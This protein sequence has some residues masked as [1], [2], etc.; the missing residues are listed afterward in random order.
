MRAG[1]ARDDAVALLVDGGLGGPPPQRLPPSLR[2]RALV[3]GLRDSPA[4]VH[5]LALGYAD[6]PPADLGLEELRLRAERLLVPAH[7]RRTL[8][9]VR[10]D[11]VLR[12][13]LAGGRRLR[14][15]PREFALLWRLSDRPGEA[16]S[17]AELLRDVFDLAFDP[18]TNSLA[19]H[20][21]RLRK[22]LALAGLPGLVV[23][24]TSTGAYRLD[25][26][27]ASP[28]ALAFALAA[29]KPLDPSARLGEQ[30]RT[31]EE[32]AP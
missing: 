16:V 8:G 22:K 1:E 5:W 18:G 31:F 9:P 4:R 12:D 13:G 14:L 2:P 19:V 15:H 10:L 25:I 32:T 24:T 3:L 6:A 26:D 20:V 17:R 7:G 29:P 21:C 11:L 30:T 28:S 23:T 27:G